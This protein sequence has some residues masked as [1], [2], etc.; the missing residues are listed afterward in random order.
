MQWHLKDC[1]FCGVCKHIRDSIRYLYSNPRTTYSQ[2][3][4]TACKAESENEEAHDKVRARSAITTEPVEGTT[5]LANHTARLMAALTMAEQGN[6]STS[7]PN[8]PRQRGCGREWIDRSTP[9]CPSSH[10]GQTGLGQTTSVHHASVRHGTGTTT[11]GGQGPNTQG[12]KEGTPNRK[13]PSFLQ[14]FRCQ[15]W[16]HMAQKCA[17]PAKT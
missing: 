16:G 4:I 11:T 8:S 5:E 13:D 1:L 7:N 9:G 6:H 2:L 12:S 3:M 14:C 15:G 17:T 10:N